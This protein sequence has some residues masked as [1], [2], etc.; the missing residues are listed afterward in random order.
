MPHQ[1][2]SRAESL[3]LKMI[4]Y[5]LA[6]LTGHLFLGSTYGDVWRQLLGQNK[7]CQLIPKHVWSLLKN[8][9]NKPRAHGYT[10]ISFAQALA[11]ID[12]QL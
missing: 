12:T 9:L 3:N 6:L 2:M 4:V 11:R 7:R 10:A 1:C 5:S 8:V